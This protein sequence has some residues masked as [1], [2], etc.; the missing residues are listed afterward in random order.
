MMMVYGLN[1][2]SIQ[3]YWIKKAIQEILLG[4]D[5]PASNIKT[6]T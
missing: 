2:T 5:N 4:G 3:E 1:H 6:A